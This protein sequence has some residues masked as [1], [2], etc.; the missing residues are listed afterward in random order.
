V[1]AVK[2]FTIT[3]DLF[4]KKRRP[5]GARVW[6]NKHPGRVFFELEQARQLGRWNTQRA[7][8]MWPWVEGDR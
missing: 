6:Q 8:R 5:V 1:K 7:W 4:K 2:G 3:I